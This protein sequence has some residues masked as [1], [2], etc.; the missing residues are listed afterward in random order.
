[1]GLYDLPASLDYIYSLNEGRKIVYVGYSQCTI[2]LFAALTRKLEY[3]QSRISLFI[4]LGPV[5]TIGHMESA[6]KYLNK[7]R[8]ESLFERF[9]IYELL[10]KNEKLSKF[11]YDR[12]PDFGSRHLH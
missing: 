11:V 3:F 6:A 1:M 9:K 12:F 5:A 2:M 10:P 8:L 4:A 7:A